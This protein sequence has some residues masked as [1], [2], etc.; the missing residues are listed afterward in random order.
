MLM[1][2]KA[3]KSL[4]NG[5]PRGALRTVEGVIG[6]GGL[7]HAVEAEAYRVQAQA[8]NELHL[9][10]Q[11]AVACE[12]SQKLKNSVELKTLK[13]E[14]YTTWLQQVEK[15]IECCPFASE[16]LILR[17]MNFFLFLISILT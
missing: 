13:K 12:K 8:A 1:V 16:L 4:T 15:E 3:E 2:L 9:F 6:M 17:L 10:D 5:N 14:I 11:A 7:P